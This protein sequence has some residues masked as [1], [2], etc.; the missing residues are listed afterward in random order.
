MNPPCCTYC[1]GAYPLSILTQMDDGAVLCPDCV[2]NVKM[3]V[4]ALARQ[5]I[6]GCTRDQQHRGGA[7]QAA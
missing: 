1:K 5:G 4:L 2:A 3:A 7:E 6:R